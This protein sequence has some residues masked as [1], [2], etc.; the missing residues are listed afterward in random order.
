[1]KDDPEINHHTEEILATLYRALVSASDD[2]DFDVDRERGVVTVEFTRRPA[3]F[4]ISPHIA[5]SQIW[6]SALSKSHKLDWDVVE[7]D[8]IL[9]STGQTLK[10]VVAEAISAQLGEE[11]TL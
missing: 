9:G 1:M 6:V 11:V 4:V 10:E 3:K 5:S 2:F 8:F 7:N